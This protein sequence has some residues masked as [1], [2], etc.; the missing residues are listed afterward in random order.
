[1]EIQNRNKNSQDAK[2]Q[3]QLVQQ[4]IAESDDKSD[5]GSDNDGNMSSTST[6]SNELQAK[7]HV[8]FTEAEIIAPETN[9]V[10]KVNQLSIKHNL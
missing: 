3:K 5:S 8:E 7:A 4:S 9:T 1:M 2:Q 6:A 10:F